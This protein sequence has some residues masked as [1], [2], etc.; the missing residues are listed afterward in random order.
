[1]I[2]Q[3]L[4]TATFDGDGDYNMKIDTNLPD[5][6]SVKKILR[7]ALVMLEHEPEVGTESVVVETYR[8]SSETDKEAGLY[9]PEEENY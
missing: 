2:F 5:N 3:V 1:M 6:E 9:W 4:L 8:A 7:D